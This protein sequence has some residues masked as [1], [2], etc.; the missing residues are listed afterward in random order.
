MGSDIQGDSVHFRAKAPDG[1]GE[2][3][4]FDINRAREVH[5]TRMQKALEEGLKDINLAKT[6]V[7]ADAARMRAQQRIEELNR[8]FEDA[9]PSE[10]VG[11]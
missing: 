2:D 11:I 9:F 6:P 3:M 5:F 8:M 10:E 4:G 1:K 7:E